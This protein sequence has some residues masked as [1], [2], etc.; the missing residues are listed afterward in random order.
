MPVMWKE[1]VF[2]F[3]LVFKILIYIHETKIYG[4]KTLRKKVLIYF[5]VKIH[6]LAF[7]YLGF[8][9][10]S[11]CVVCINKHEVVLAA[12][13][14]INFMSFYVSVCIISFPI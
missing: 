14:H 4:K 9:T 8:L 12:K 5:Y 2:V 6:I 10:Q 3:I 1:N 13:I 7:I 11:S